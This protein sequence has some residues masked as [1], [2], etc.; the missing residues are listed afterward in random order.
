MKR[1]DIVIAVVQGAFGKPRPALVVQS[2]AFND[3][4]AT[5]VLCLLT[6]DVTDAPL[7]RI[8]V[9]PTPANGLAQKSQIMVDKLFAL[10]RERIGK[11]V[12]VLD[13]ATMLRVNRTLALWLGLGD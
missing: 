5:I 6:S 13:D 11:A 10:R 9:E 2:D 7:F 3:T 8:D 1:G 4:H 12:G